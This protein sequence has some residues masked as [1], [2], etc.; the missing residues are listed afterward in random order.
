MIYAAYLPVCLKNS[1]TVMDSPLGDAMISTP[2]SLIANTGGSPSTTGLP[3]LLI[4]SNMRSYSVGLVKATRSPASDL[5]TTR[6]S[7]APVYYTMVPRF[8][9]NIMRSLL[10]SIRIIM[11]KNNALKCETFTL[12]FW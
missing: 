5:G 9:P 11:L 6:S 1:I 7:R 8:V 2:T 3:E 10:V 4:S 12:T